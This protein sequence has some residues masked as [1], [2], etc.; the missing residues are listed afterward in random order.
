M[1]AVIKAVEYA[2]PENI[3]TNEQLAD[4]FPE[5]TAEKI[6]K[7][8]GIVTRHI[9]GEDECASDLAVEAARKVFSKGYCRSGDVDFLLCC[10]QSPDYILPT[11]ACLLQ[12]R[13]SLSTRTGALDFNL[14]CSGYIYGLGLAKGLV[15]TGQARNVLLVTADTYSKYLHQD[16]KGVRTLFGDGASATLI[17]SVDRKTGADPL[18]PFC[19]GT[20]GRGAKNFIV[21]AG[22]CRTLR[23]FGHGTI[24][25]AD[26]NSLSIEE[27]LFMD[28]PEIFTFS[29]KVVPDVVEQV[30]EKADLQIEWVD[31]FIFHQANKYMLEF[32]RKKIKIPADKFYN[33]LSRTGN[34]VSSSIPIAMKQAFN[35]GLLSAGQRILL[36]G[37]GVGYSWGATLIEWPEEFSG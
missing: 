33:P 32:L 18:G 7:K 9:A 16:D 1:R 6:E 20:D 22:G 11:T 34:T 12:E 36:A 15:E 37:F 31:F 2:L 13:L 3:L 14:G 17:T 19:Y 26:R 10:T 28:G 23:S 5:W 4:E 24:R 27:S 35:D 29:I 30:L 8:L 25:S 21:P